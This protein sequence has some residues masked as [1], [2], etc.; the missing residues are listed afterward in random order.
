MIGI[1]L[2]YFSI[3]SGN[4]PTSGLRARGA[5]RYAVPYGRY[6]G[7]TVCTTKQ[8][9]IQHIYTYISVAILAQGCD[10]AAT[11]CRGLGVPAGQVRP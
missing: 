4:A 7:S 8:I 10:L 3:F 1:F 9:C 6:V 11:L 2:V 5:S